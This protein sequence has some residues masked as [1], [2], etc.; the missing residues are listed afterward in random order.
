MVATV[1]VKVTAIVATAVTAATTATAATIAIVT[2]I[3]VVKLSRTEWSRAEAAEK[4][5]MDAP[6]MIRPAQDLN[7]IL[8]IGLV[9]GERETA[10][11]ITRT[12]TV[13]IVTSIVGGVEPG[14]NSLVTTVEWLRGVRPANNVMFGW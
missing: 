8:E 3:P 12:L 1:I 2:V 10:E 6:A 11:D 7:M 14:T 9:L 4:R 13:I 5:E